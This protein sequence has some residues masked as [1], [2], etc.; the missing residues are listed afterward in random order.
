MIESTERC[1]IEVFA[2][3]DYRRHIWPGL[4]GS[5][6]ETDQRSRRPPNN[7]ADSIGTSEGLGIRV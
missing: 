7:K 4:P 1:G 3:Q 5:L 6:D 2:D